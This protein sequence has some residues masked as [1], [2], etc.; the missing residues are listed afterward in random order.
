MT[1]SAC[2]RCDCV[3]TEPAA[4]VFADMATTPQTRTPAHVSMTA[5]V[6]YASSATVMPGS[7]SSTPTA[8]S[9]STAS[10]SPSPVASDSSA[11]ILTM[12]TNS[13]PTLSEPTQS[14]SRQ[15]PG[16]TLMPA[17][18]PT[19]D[20]THLST[21]QPSPLS[22]LAPSPV[23]LGTAVSP[24]P[25]ASTASLM[26][27]LTW[28]SLWFEPIYEC[29]TLQQFACGSEC[30]NGFFCALMKDEC[31][32]VE[33]EL[34]GVKKRM[35][36]AKRMPPASGVAP[37][38]NCDFRA[39]STDLA[40]PIG[41]G[42]AAGLLL[43]LLVSV[44]IWCALSRRQR[45]PNAVALQPTVT[46]APVGIYGSLPVLDEGATPSVAANDY[47]VVPRPVVAEYE[48]VDSRLEIK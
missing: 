24:L 32:C 33:I 2:E 42:I 19:T 7:S 45:A 8:T 40:L 20:W 31:S 21:L 1:Q 28:T 11:V 16:A 23:P 22:T 5:G 34:P 35:R 47:D 29:P 10:V 12:S 43:I 44:A 46:N 18:S 30:P 38:C 17:P 4:T 39:Q 26:T 13:I 25:T 15:T 41:V 6:L 37:S 9:P 14:S 36:L 27:R 48:A 3:W